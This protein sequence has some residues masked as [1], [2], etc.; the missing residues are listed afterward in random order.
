MGEAHFVKRS[1]AAGLL[2]AFERL[3]HDHVS[4]A[5]WTWRTDVQP[6]V[7]CQFH[8]AGSYMLAELDVSV[9]FSDSIEAR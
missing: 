1:E 3:D 2:P 8:A 5:A 7:A 4:A 6:H 9:L